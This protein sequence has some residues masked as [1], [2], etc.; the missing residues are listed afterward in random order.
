ML[1][2]FR[3]LL[4]AKVGI[5]RWRQHYNEVRPYMSLGYQTPAEFKATLSEGRSPAA[6]ALTRKTMETTDR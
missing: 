3:S 6:R 4:E 2:W 1:E 5:E